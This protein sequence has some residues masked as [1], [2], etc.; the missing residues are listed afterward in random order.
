MTYSPSIPQPTDLISVSQG[1]LLTNF[2]TINTWFGVDQYPFNFAG[3]APAPYDIAVAGDKGKAKQITFV[4]VSADISN[5]GANEIGLYNKND[6][7]GTQQL[8]MRR[9]SGG[10]VLQMTGATTLGVPGTSYIPGG[11]AL[12]WG[13]FT[14]SGSSSV[15]AYVSSF[16]TATFAVMLTPL[17][18]AAAGSTSW[19]SANSTTGFTITNSGTV[20]NA[21]WQYL[22]VGS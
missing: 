11:A 19:I 21:S 15:Q 3:G 4:R 2:S 7:G 10:T 17:N 20:T 6:S 16:T 8:F 9:P 14:Y 5:A 18:S 13:T 22:A 1:D 12:M